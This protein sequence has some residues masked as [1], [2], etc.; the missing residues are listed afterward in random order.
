MD[1]IADITLDILD[2]QSGGPEGRYTTHTTHT[3]RHPIMFA[4]SGSAQDIRHGGPWPPHP[5]F[6]SFWAYDPIT[7]C[8]GSY[9][10]K[11]FLRMA[12]I[13]KM[14]HT[15]KP[16]YEHRRLNTRM[17]TQREYEQYQ[18]PE[19]KSEHQPAWRPRFLDHGVPDVGSS[20]IVRVIVCAL[21][22]YGLYHLIF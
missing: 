16:P 14:L 1:S 3:V 10:G 5:A 15:I 12:G 21:A 2:T 20:L 8:E 6:A 9:F 19:I 13:V 22:L 18:K 4:D 7:V 11:E 17:P